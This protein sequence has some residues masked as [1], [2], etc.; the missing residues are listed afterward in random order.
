MSMSGSVSERRDAVTATLTTAAPVWRMAC[1]RDVRSAGT[2][3][4]SCDEMT[5]L[6]ACCATQIVE[7]GLPFDVDVVGPEIECAPKH[8]ST[9]LFAP[10]KPARPPTSGGT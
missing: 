5:T 8:R 3:L 6:L 7:A 4:K 9:L 2:P 1:A 10:V